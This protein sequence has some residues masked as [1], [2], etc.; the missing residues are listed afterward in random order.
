MTDHN[1]PQLIAVR[2]TINI[3]A[4]PPLRIGQEA[5][6]DPTNPNVAAWLNA[7]YLIPLP[8]DDG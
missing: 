4:D 2:A 8:D 5:L 1:Q 6:V 3:H 7:L